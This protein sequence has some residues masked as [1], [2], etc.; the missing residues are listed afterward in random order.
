MILIN[1][2]AVV[3]VTAGV[4]TLMLASETPALERA[5][6][7]REAAAAVAIA[8]GGELTAMAA[9]RRDRDDDSDDRT[10]AWARVAQASTPIAGGTFALAI[11]DAQARFNINTAGPDATTLARFIAAAGLP[12][13]VGAQI[14]A[15]IARDGAIADLADLA[16]AGI[17]PATIAALRP[18]VTA[19]PGAAPINV[20]AAPAAVLGV[21]IGDPAKGRL[22]AARRDRAGRLTPADFDAVPPGAGFT[23]DHF[24][25]TTTV[26]IGTTTRT[27]VSQL[28]R[29]RADSGR[30][31]VIVVARAYR[32][33]ARAR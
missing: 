23:S 15:A 33:E 12:A 30:T 29:S 4:A 10:E 7:L 31:E 20:N 32:P 13:A 9:L 26:T 22:L 5:I 6:R 14:G 18:Y 16:N 28:H 21:M 1:V 2:L 17:D 8:R 11:D 27:L 3:A 25:V 19:L 24:T